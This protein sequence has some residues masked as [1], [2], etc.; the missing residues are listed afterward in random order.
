MYEHVVTP[1]NA[2]LVESK[3][4]KC[5]EGL[6]TTNTRELGHGS[7][8]HSLNGD[9]LGG[10]G[11]AASLGI[12]LQIKPDGLADIGIEFGVR[13]GLG[14]TPRKCGHAR[15]QESLVISLDDHGERP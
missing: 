4:P 8:L 5:P 12:N 1:S 9:E 6:G 10:V 11:V 15:H 14:V 13:A 3:A 7:N 2:D